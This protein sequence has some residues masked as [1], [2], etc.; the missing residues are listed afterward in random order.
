MSLRKQFKMDQARQEHGA[1]VVFPPNADKSVPTIWLRR[2]TANDGEYQ[3]AMTRV[4]TPHRRAQELGALPEGEFNALL[5]EVFAEGAIARWENVL[6]SDVLDDDTAEGFAECTTENKVKLLKNL[7][8]LHGELRSFAVQRENYLA[9]NVE[10]DA[11][12]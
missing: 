7:P 12:N 8:E 3:K 1:P 5:L 9:A 10:A 4:M 2:V 11:K 6:L